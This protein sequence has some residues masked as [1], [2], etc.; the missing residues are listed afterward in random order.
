MNT[1]PSLTTYPS[2]PTI[3]H[4]LR[5]QLTTHPP[6]LLPSTRH[7]VTGY[8]SYTYSTSMD[9]HKHTDNDNDN[10]NEGNEGGGDN[11]AGKSNHSHYLKAFQVHHTTPF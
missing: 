1:N 8:G 2:P 10:S 4:L 9:A 3:P 7:Y 6:P 5:P 11:G